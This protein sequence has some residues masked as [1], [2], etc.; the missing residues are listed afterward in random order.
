[1]DTPMFACIQC[2]H[3]TPLDDVQLA[4]SDGSRCICYRCWRA[5]VTAQPEPERP[6]EPPAIPNDGHHYQ[7]WW[8]VTCRAGKALRLTS[9]WRPDCPVCGRTLRRWDEQWHPRGG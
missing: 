7:R 2:H 3:P 9:L 8:C 5:S 6:P 1:M 4:M